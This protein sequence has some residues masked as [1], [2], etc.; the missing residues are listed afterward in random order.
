MKKSITK[1]SLVLTLTNDSIKFDAVI[2]YKKPIACE[3]VCVCMSINYCTAES[4][5]RPY[6][7]RMKILRIF[8]LRT[9]IAYSRIHTRFISLS[10]MAD[11]SQL[12]GIHSRM[13]LLG[14]TE[15]RYFLSVFLFELFLLS[16]LPALLS[17][18]ARL[19]GS[20]HYNY[21]H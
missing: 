1:R 7:P 19:N 11:I 17:I 6:L 12:I 20:F 16:P 14:R 5:W 2:D 21:V 8:F 15:F 9:Q 10:N 13:F 3:C 4:N 18:V